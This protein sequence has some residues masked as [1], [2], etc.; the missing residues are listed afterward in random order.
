MLIAMLSAS[1]T[2][3]QPE[4]EVVI[5]GKTPV[6]RQDKIADKAKPVVCEGGI[7]NS[8]A[9]RLPEPEYPPQAKAS[10]AKGRVMVKVQIDE[11]GNVTTAV[12]CS[13]PTVLREAAVCAA[14]KARFHP[15]LIKGKPVG[16]A[17]VLTYDFVA[18]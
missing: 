7:L 5:Q 17:G 6:V 9:M 18:L 1:T 15:T 2:A 8:R 10:R 3:R 13:G 14:Y 4:N 12:A 11:E 16:V